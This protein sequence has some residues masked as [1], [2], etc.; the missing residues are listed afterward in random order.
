MTI[1]KV[2]RDI[3]IPNVEV[4]TLCQYVQRLE[5]NGVFSILRNGAHMLLTRLFV[6]LC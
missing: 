1:I 4:V 6:D 2:S 3:R 5:L